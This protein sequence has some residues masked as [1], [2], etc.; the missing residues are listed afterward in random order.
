MPTDTSAGSFLSKQAA[1][2]II[3]KSGPIAAISPAFPRRNNASS[4][5]L[6]LALRSCAVSWSRRF[7]E[8]IELP[9]GRKLKTLAEATAGERHSEVR[10]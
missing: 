1:A 9:D 2:D 6:V 4:R 8:P 3:T 10:T 5:P 7:E